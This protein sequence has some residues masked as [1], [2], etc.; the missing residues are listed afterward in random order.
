MDEPPEVRTPRLT[1]PQ[2]PRRPQEPSQPDEVRPVRRAARSGSAPRSSVS[3]AG[4]GAG[5]DV[6]PTDDRF[7]GPDDLADDRS[8]RSDGPADE[9]VRLPRATRSGPRML[10]VFGVVVVV[11]GI[12]VLS[13]VFWATRQISP[14]GGQ[15]AAVAEVVVPKGASSDAIAKLLEE[16]KVVTNARMFRW[17]T[18]WKSAG[19]WK[20][21]RYVA[22]KQNSSFDEA[23]AVLDKGPVAI[24]A[25]TVRIA[26]GRRL[27]DAL[28][29]INKA[30]PNLSVGELQATLASG[31]VSSKYKPDDVANWEGFLF[32]D[33]YE[34][35]DTASAQEVLQTM[36][37]KM[38][39]V[40]DELGYAKAQ[41]LQG[42][43]PYELVTIASLV[44]R[45]T[46]QPA[47]ERGKIARVIM[48]RLE[49]G[50]PLGIDA[51]NLYGLGRTSGT[52]S[53]ADLDVDSPYN[54]RKFK[55]L[56]PTPVCLPGKASLAAAIQAPQGSWRYYVLTTKDPPSHFFTDSYKEFVK[57]KADA[58]ARGVF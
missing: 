47:D 49:A 27:A 2:D 35:L 6:R 51:A 24:D 57:A 25:V 11:L 36:A 56:P 43:T 13:I 52:L 17:Y 37:T 7:D 23:I 44:E 5:R 1:D 34:F 20:A 40:L 10:A 28:A 30:F 14:S 16:A 4:R 50:E 15:G 42:R 41:A 55:G 19:P 21:G 48:N 32:P 38:D 39:K 58:Q 12:A 53:K 8:V 22:F 9:Y 3:G 29:D 45:E 54:V 46:G 31:A 18:S 33:T 26:E